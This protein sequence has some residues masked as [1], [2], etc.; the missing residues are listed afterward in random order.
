MNVYRVTGNPD[1]DGYLNSI[2]G[3]AETNTQN[4][5]QAFTDQYN[6][7]VNNPSNYSIPRRARLGVAFNF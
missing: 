1:D 5:P 7:K 6:I 3:I 2:D 4:D